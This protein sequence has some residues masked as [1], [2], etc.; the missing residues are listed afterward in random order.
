[1]G[2]VSGT[3]GKRYIDPDKCTSCGTCIRNCSA[4]AITVETVEHM[5]PELEKVE[6]YR[7][8]IRRLEKELAESQERYNILDR[9]LRLLIAHL[10]TATFI[11]EREGRIVTANR[12]FAEL[13]GIG[14]LRLADLPEDLAG[15]NLLNLL[16]DD[17]GKLIRM[18]VSEASD[19]CYV[20][21]IGSQEVSFSLTPLT[22]NYILGIGRT[23]DDPAVAGEQVLMLLREVIDRKMTMVQKIGS[24]LGEETSAEINSLTTIMQIIESG[25]GKTTETQ[26]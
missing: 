13:S 6:T 17:V 2:A 19:R 9:C 10:P 1:M 15:E 7:N 18:S 8:R 22:D 25:D 20:I 3:S 26:E 12:A 5:V 14:P 11:I 16:P 23:L 21:Q 4:G 24:L